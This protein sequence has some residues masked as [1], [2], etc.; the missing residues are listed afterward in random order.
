MQK[1]E[2]SHTVGGS[3]NWY[4]QNGKLFDIIYQ[5][6]SHAYFTNPR[7]YPF[8][9]I[10]YISTHLSPK[11]MQKKVYSSTILNT[12]KLQTTHISMKWIR[13]LWYIDWTEYYTEIRKK[14]TVATCNNYI[15]HK[16]M[17]AKR[18]QPD[19]STQIIIFHFH[20]VQK[21]AKVNYYKW[22]LLECGCVFSSLEC[23]KVAVF[24]KQGFILLST[25]EFSFM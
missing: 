12:S 18:S 14:Q 22:G 13:K 10:K 24:T 19:I 1:L 5:S 20:T 3:V 6:Y 8:A 2:L 15:S 23:C 11:D 17:S 9:H 7:F 4:K 25:Y 21:Q 16:I